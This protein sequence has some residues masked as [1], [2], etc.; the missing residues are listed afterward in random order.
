MAGHEAA[1]PRRGARVLPL[2]LVALLG[3]CLFTRAGAQDF[4]GLKLSDGLTGYRKVFAW[5]SNRYG[6][7]GI[8]HA[9]KQAR[10][11]FHSARSN[12]PRD[13]ITKLTSVPP[14][15]RYVHPRRRRNRSST[16]A[17][18]SRSS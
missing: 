17:R 2:L 18:A 6:E 16:A 9:E 15:P 4:T 8:N 5:G 13:G 11:F 1:M 14:H 10:L 3:A 12:L 7:L